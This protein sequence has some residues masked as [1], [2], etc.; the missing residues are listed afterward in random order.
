MNMMTTAAEKLKPQQISEGGRVAHRIAG[1]TRASVN[2]KIG[3]PDK[4][5]KAGESDTALR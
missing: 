5:Q 4:F 1:V 3:S 2:K